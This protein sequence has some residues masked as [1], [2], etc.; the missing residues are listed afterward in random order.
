MPKNIK[1]LIFNWQDIKN[2]LGGGAEVHL[3]EIFKRIVAKG[4]EVTLVCCEI[5]GEPKDEVIDGITIM[6]RGSRNTFNFVVPKL[7]KKLFM[8][9]GY[10]VIID[11]VNKIPFYLPLFIGKKLLVISHHFFG[12]S[13]FHETN[14]IAGLYVVIAEKLVDYIYKKHPIVTVSQ[15]TKDEFISRGFDEDKI[16]I[17]HNAI[18]QEMYPMAVVPKNPNFTITYFGRLKKY[19]SVDNMFDAFEI[20]HKKYPD[21]RLEIIG[22]GDYRPKLEE[23]ASKGGYSDKVKFH[24]FVTDEQ[25]VDLLGKAHV[26]VN[27]SMKEGWGITNIEANACGTPIISADS[28]GLR[29]SVK[30]GLSGDLYEYGNVPELTQKLE[31]LITNPEL[32]QKLSAGAVEWAKEFSWDKS[33]NEMM[34]EI[35]KIVYR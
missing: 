35:D 1:I 19:K 26:V 15:S 24:G 2:P 9:K 31:E 14:V 12:K 18:E 20:L 11:D 5:P 4:H 8:N 22:R 16:A 29:D 17:V 30:V 6:R 10:D 7:Y 27:T 33:A 28:P 32:L 13:I 23:L 34:R 3:H 21:I 25:K